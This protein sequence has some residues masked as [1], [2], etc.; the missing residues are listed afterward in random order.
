M[1]MRAGQLPT[2]LVLNAL[3]AFRVNT[4]G[5]GY[6]GF[7]PQVS[8][9]TLTALAGLTIAQGNIIYGTGA[10]AFAVLAKDANATRYI[11][12]QGTSNNPIWS[13]VNLANGV[14]GTLPIA[15]G[16]TN[17]TSFTNTRIP[18]FNGTS[19]VDD[20]GLT[21]DATNDRLTTGDL[22]LTNTK[23]IQTTRTVPATNGDAVDIGS[24]SFTNGAGELEIIITIPS[25]GY[26]Q[27]KRYIV[28]IRFDATGGGWKKVNAIAST[29]AYSGIDFDLEYNGASA[30]NAFRIRKTSGST[31]GTAYITVIQQGVI[32]DAFTP[33]T[34]TSTPAAPTTSYEP[35]ADAL[36][37][38]R[39]QSG[40][41]PVDPGSFSFQS[42]NATGRPV[43]AAFKAMTDNTIGTTVQA[44]EPA[45][46][47]YREGLNGVAY[48]NFV[49][50]KVSRWEHNG[51][52]ARSALTVAATHGAGD[53]TG[54]N[55]AEFRSDGRS[56][57]H[58]DIYQ[59]AGNI[60]P[61]LVYEALISQT[62]T[63]APTAAM[64]KNTLGT[65]TFNR[66]AGGSYEILSSGLFSTQDKCWFSPV[67][68]N[69]ID[70]DWRV[71]L[72]YSSSSKI[73]LESEE[74][75]S[76]NGT[77]GLLNHFPISIRVKKP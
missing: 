27:S 30:V 32:A 58:G 9:A 53:A 17:A 7:V 59:T 2:N 19:L 26:S 37:S 8:D 33:S 55:I 28:P 3:E 77:D 34:S 75:V 61:Y 63:S 69:D 57:F 76:G 24:W 23:T 45:L 29:G 66:V 65:V 54:T 1:T 49:E 6:E 42:Y 71:K 52:N 16:G 18:Y 67:R 68:T 73:I 46:V 36:L 40:L 70:A 5:N 20:S 48:A 64:N 50:L 21:Y 35:R 39:F 13:Q 41:F 38:T 10:D 4:A 12:N 60:E 72:T 31:G 44:A 22:T 43:G 25:S 14:T 47:I 56:T 62:G 15:N 74:I 51:A 11:S